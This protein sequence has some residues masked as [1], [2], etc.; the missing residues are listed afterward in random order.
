MPNDGNSRVS[1]YTMCANS[2]DPTFKPYLLHRHQVRIG[3]ERVL[4]LSKTKISQKRTTCYELRKKLFSHWWTYSLQ[5]D[6]E[7]LGSPSLNRKRTSSPNSERT[8]CRIRHQTDRIRGY[9]H[10]VRES[11]S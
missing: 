3:T 8:I 2:K 6:L 11:Q 5:A 4:Q 7:L 10:Q 1:K 9:P